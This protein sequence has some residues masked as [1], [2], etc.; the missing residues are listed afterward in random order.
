[1][2][3]IKLKPCPVCGCE[4]VVEAVPKNNMEDVTSFRI[5]KQEHAK[6]CILGAMSN[7]TTMLVEFGIRRAEHE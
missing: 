2:N 1:M 3:E 4:M 5:K 6:D 7:G